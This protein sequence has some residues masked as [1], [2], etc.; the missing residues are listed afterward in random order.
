MVDARSVNAKKIHTHTRTLWKV[1]LA[2]SA[3]SDDPT[4]TWYSTLLQYAFSINSSRVE[5]LTMLGLAGGTVF[6][7]KAFG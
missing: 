7:G 2:D 3:L 1:Q 5:Y 4:I 6:V